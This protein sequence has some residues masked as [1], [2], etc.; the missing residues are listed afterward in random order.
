MLSG[1]RTESV[2]R[3]IIADSKEPSAQSCLGR[4]HRQAG[5][6][7]CPDGA[8]S[9]T[10]SPL[11]VSEHLVHLTHRIAQESC[12]ICW[13]ICG[14]IHP[15]SFCLFSSYFLDFVLWETRTGKRTQK[16]FKESTFPCS[17]ALSSRFPLLLRQNCPL[18]RKQWLSLE[19]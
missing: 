7:I 2:P 9:W 17:S 14:R 18:L 3:G 4:P 12:W 5:L 16:A 15:S 13:L 8:L 6:I 11:C 10:T 1:S 19:I